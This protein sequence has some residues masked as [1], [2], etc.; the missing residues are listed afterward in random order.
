[1]NGCRKNGLTAG[2]Y[3]NK[4]VLMKKAEEELIKRKSEEFS[5]LYNGD[6]SSEEFSTLIKKCSEC[7]SVESITESDIDS[8]Y[9]N[10]F[11][12]NV[13]KISEDIYLKAMIEALKIQFLIAGTDF[14]SSRQRDLGQK[15]SDTIRGYLGE[16][17]VKLWFKKRWNIDIDLGHEE[18]TLEEY[19]PTDI[20][21]VKTPADSDFR[22]ANLK[23][24][25][26]STKSNGI[27]LDIPGDQFHH[28]DIFI[29]TKLIITTDHLFS[30]FKAI[31]VFEDKILKLGLGKG[32]LTQEAANQIYNNIPSFKPVYGYIAGFV[33][34]SKE[35]EEYD[36]EYSIGKTNAKLYG[37]SGVYK[38]DETLRDI[39]DDINRLETKKTVNKCEF[40]GIRKFNS[41]KRYV[42]GMRNLRYSK[43]EWKE[44]VIDKI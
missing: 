33:K 35:Y 15:W 16:F 41:S 14:G 17:G 34:Y 1:M 27:W 44:F 3:F 32:L 24:S 6:I 10:R 21:A 12:S 4:G 38:G 26:K 36:Y 5:D 31:S 7:K 18:G 30:F 29:L 13:F 11:K 2:V 28:S 37:Y 40:E 25:I 9:N 23:V 20:H 22:E 8:W 42:F 19:L 39:K 43:E